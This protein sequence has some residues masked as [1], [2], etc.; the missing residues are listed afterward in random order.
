MHSSL[1]ANGSDLRTAA[2]KTS[3]IKGNVKGG[4]A[5]VSANVSF[6]YNS[7]LGDTE[8]DM[9]NND[10]TYSQHTFF[11]TTH[12]MVLDKP[13]VRFNGKGELK[14][15]WPAIH[16]YAK[17]KT[18]GAEIFSSLRYALRTRDLFW[19]ARASAGNGTLRKRCLH[20]CRTAR[21]LAGEQRRKFPQI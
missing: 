9:Y 19:G 14:G 15:F 12:T 4:C 20:C 5:F 10:K 3:S 13:N 18:S 7:E 2:T 16:E 1:I 8:E 21:K 6:N 17:G 11:V